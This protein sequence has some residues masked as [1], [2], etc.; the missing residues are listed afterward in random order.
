MTYSRSYQLNS[1]ELLII[2]HF[3]LLSIFV[4]HFNSAYL[5]TK[6]ATFKLIN[7]QKNQET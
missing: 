6:I 5:E 2:I 1:F 3:C 4:M 7:F